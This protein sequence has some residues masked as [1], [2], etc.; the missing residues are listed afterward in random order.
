MRRPLTFDNLDLALAE[1]HSL[2][3]SGYTKSGNWSLAQISCH[4]RRTIEKNREGYPWWMAS[5]GYPLRPILRWL[6]LP[7]LLR[8]ESPSGVKTA[9]IFVPGEDLD[10]ASEVERL[11]QCV[12]DFLASDEP[13][14]PHPGFGSMSKQQFNHFH[15]AH[16]AHHLSF[17]HPVRHAENKPAGHP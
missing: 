15:A 9:G 16:A 12:V 17:L 10:D 1:C 11:R 13:L 4:L 2:L 5:A 8:G 14:Y 6:L 7:K 3:E